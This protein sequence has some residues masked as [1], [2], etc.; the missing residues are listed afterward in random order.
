MDIKKV[1]HVTVCI[2]TAVIA[3]GVLRVIGKGK[4]TSSSKAGTHVTKL[5][6]SSMRKEV[7][8]SD[9][10]VCEERMPEEDIYPS[11]EHTPVSDTYKS[12]CSEY[13]SPEC[14]DSNCNTCSD[15]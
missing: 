7:Y 9:I 15:S 4:K 6:G 2:S 8:A 12:A 5:G 10:D 11:L 1:L 14:S 3:F 13:Q